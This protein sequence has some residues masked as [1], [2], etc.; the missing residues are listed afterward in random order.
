VEVRLEEDALLWE[1]SAEEQEQEGEVL[2]LGPW[3][4]GEVLTLG[5]WQGEEVLKVGGSPVLVL[6]PQ[7]A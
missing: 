2:T 3:Q 4:E 6:T 7:S 1:E 5:P